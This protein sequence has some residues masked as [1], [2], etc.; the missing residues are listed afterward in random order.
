M[1]RRKEIDTVVAPAKFTGELRNGH[2]LGHG[3]SDTRQLF[4]LLYGGA[5][6]SLLGKCTDV[7]FIN[8]LTFHF[9]S[10]PFC[11]APWELRWINYAGGTVRSLGLKTRGRIGIKIFFAI[12]PKPVTRAG[13]GARSTGEIAVGLGH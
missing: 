2:H 1:R 3:N 5:P 10:G 13:T 4:Q 7:H 9:H 6:R 8:D 12:Y 11:V